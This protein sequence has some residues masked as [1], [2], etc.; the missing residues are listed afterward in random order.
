MQTLYLDLE[1]YS[2]TP[3][4]R[5][6]HAYAANAEILLAAWAW[7]DAPVQVLDLTLPNTRHDGI[8]QA[9]LDPNVEVVIHNSHFD[10][11]VIRHVWGINIP[12]E[13][14]HDTM[15]QAMAHSLPGSLGMLCEVLGLPS[16]KAKDT[17][18]IMAACTIIGLAL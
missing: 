14:I 13:R 15:V 2:E 18:N 5:G 11:T 1:T 6:T 10:R 7:D 8:A 9:L 17:T 4:T 12:T 16:D 3:I